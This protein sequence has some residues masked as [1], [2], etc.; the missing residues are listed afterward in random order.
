MRN[1]T[2]TSPGRY[3]NP[4]LRGTQPDPSVVRVGRDF[5]LATSSFDLMP[6]IQ[7]R[8][9][10]NLVDWHLIGCAVER[11]AQYR[12]DGT[13]G[14]I[15]LFAPT[16]RYH[17]GEFFLVCT[18]VAENQGHFVLRTTDPRLGWSDALWLD[19]E[20]FDP[21]LFFDVDGLCYYTRRTMDRLPDGRLG[22]IVQAELDIETGALGTF[23]E[24]TPRHGGFCSNDIEG[25]HLYRVGDWYYLFSAEGGSWFG[26]MQ[27]IARSRSPWGP[28]ESA[29]HNP[30]L[31]HRNRVGHP[32]QTLGHADL[33][34]A[35]DGSWWSLSLGTRHV[36][37]D[38]FALHHN[39][40]RETF[41]APVEWI[42]GWPVI[43]NGGTLELEMQLDRPLPGSRQPREG[44]KESGWRSIGTSSEALSLT[45]SGSY[46]VSFGQALAQDLK[47]DPVGAAL[48]AQTEDSQ[49]FSVT[50]D[51]PPPGCAAGVGVYSDRLHHYVAQIVTT[52]EGDALV[53]FSRSVDDLHTVEERRISVQP[54]YSLSILAGENEYAFGL[55]IG[56][57][58][59]SVGSG[60]A[61]LLSAEVAEWFIGTYFAL[62][63]TGA[64]ETGIRAVFSDIKRVDLEDDRLTR[65]LGATS[66]FSGAA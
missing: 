40:G 38:G 54:R 7:I 17:D 41:L 60:S 25:P 42:D 55:S 18:N 44:I 61:R 63:A 24:L 22:P 13:P 8:H 33:V 56:D 45:A 10:T 39:L 12:R 4:V 62:V 11:P 51:A 59:E 1:A 30:V 58:S 66:A 50:V 34:D 6:G 26:H 27:T 52:D 36:G 65:G 43:G 28:F 35:V 16:L 2:A 9:S 5:Y 46:E 15:S 47:E 48:V 19:R 57:R 32:I 37:R 3:T 23:R 49:S 21:S 14:P 53:R 64:S 29:P 20:A 31:T